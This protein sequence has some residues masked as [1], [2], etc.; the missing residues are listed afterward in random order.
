[1]SDDV[2]T[3]GAVAAMHKVRRYTVLRWAKAGLLPG[4]V[5]DNGWWYF[6]RAVAAGF[7]RRRQARPAHEGCTVGDCPRRHHARHLCK[8]HYQR[9]QR[10]GDVQ[11]GDPIERRWFGQYNRGR[12]K[13]AFDPIDTDEL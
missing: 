8:P 4:R 2:L 11:A 9:W 3:T 10:T 6:D 5:G 13:P 7:V 12:V 1:M